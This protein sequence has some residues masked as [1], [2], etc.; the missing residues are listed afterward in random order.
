MQEAL[1]ATFRTIERRAK[2]YRLVIVLVAAIPLSAVLAAAISRSWI[3]LI[4]LVLVIPVTGLFHL[5]DG[6]HV[7]LWRREI[8]ELT[9]ASALDLARFTKALSSMR[10]V[11]QQTV[12]GMLA[13]LSKPHT[14]GWN[15]LPPGDMPS[16]YLSR[17]EKLERR[18]EF[19]ALAGSLA[20]A[21]ALAFLL[22]WIWQ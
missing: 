22:A 11:P 19:Q 8:V 2:L 20:L 14:E 18:R 1:N 6:R 13:S 7:R 4:G 15:H 16:A 17:V 12:Q 10:M 5:L 3:P 21:G 9:A